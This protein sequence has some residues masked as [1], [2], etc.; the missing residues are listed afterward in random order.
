MFFKSIRVTLTIWHLGILSLIILAFATATYQLVSRRLGQMASRNLA[1]TFEMVVLGLYEEE[2]DVIQR[3]EDLRLTGH[4]EGDLEDQAE[5]A[6]IE[7]AIVA[8]VD[9]LNLRGFVVEVHD[10]SGT[11]LVSTA[12]DDKGRVAAAGLSGRAGDIEVDGAGGSWRVQHRLLTFDGKDFRVLVAHPLE[13]QRAFM[14][15]LWQI[16]CWAVPVALVLAGCGGYFLAGRSLAPVLLI[17]RQAQR[18]SST[19]LHERLPVRNAADELGGLAIVLNALLTRLGSAFEQQQRFIADASHELR[20]PLTIVRAESE[21]A[22][23]GDSRSAEEFRESMTV[24]HEESR[25]LCGIVDDLFLL[26]TADREQFQPRLKWINMK[27]VLGG[28]I[29]AVRTLAD[30]RE[31]KICFSGS[32]EMPVSADEELLHRLFLNLLDNSIKYNRPG[33]QVLVETRKGDASY[34]VTISDTGIGIPTGDQL[35]VF[36]RFYRADDA[37]VLDLERNAG[38]AGLG[39]SIAAWISRVHRATLTLEKSDPRGS[40]FQL[41]FPIPS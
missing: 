27:Q 29:R 39:L 40:V 34:L 26:A 32:D 1:D 2:S 9:G 24:V 30:K 6:S 13:E 23:S 7:T 19:N 14:A 12:E 37:R 17:S 4:A 38:G 3:R 21:V 33:G 16:F 36:D 20:T 18:I 5:E 8:E 22:L 11:L 28:S 25:R 15:S 31:V 10:S 35:K 41:D